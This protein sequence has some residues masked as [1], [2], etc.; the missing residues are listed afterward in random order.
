MKT[1]LFD[2]D[3]TLILTGGAGQ[4]A[5]AETFAELFDVPE[6]TTDISFAGRS[7]RAITLDLMRAH[8]VA[9]SEEN[10]LRFRQGYAER[11]PATLKR[12][13][14]EVLPGVEALVTK[15]QTQG[16]V[17]IGLL[18]GNLEQTAQMKLAYYGL[19]DYFACG[20]YGDLHTNRNDI[21]SAAVKQAAQHHANNNT[22]GEHLVVVIGDT[23]H[24]V[25]C[26]HSVGA[27]A[28]AVPTG[29]TPSETLRRANPELLVDTLEDCETILEWFAE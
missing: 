20:G 19:W 23:Q 21:A 26:A 4:V 6:I 7:D 27:R 25:T 5:F 12:C 14:G 24:D 18:T 17:L 3:G 28:V 16:D 9:G 29:H 13:P 15:L 1:C 10:W 2:I 8:G 22:N 11:L